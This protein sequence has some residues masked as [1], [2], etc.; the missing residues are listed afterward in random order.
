MQ[1]IL[2]KVYKKTIINIKINKTLYLILLGEISLCL[3]T[4]AY[5]P[6]NPDLKEDC[7]AVSKSYDCS[8]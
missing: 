7:D 5:F 8:V 6:E 2:L 3:D 4:T 1:V